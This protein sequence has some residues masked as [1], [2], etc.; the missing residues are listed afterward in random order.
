MRGAPRL[1]VAL[2]LALELLAPLNR[3]VQAPYFISSLPI[4]GVEL[5]GASQDPRM[6]HRNVP[7]SAA[8][9]LF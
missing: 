5:R 9:G 7:A 4:L 6:Q 2:S 1:G 8:H 3:R